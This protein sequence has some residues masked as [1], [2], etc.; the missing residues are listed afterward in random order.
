MHLFHNR[1]YRTK[2]R[3][4]FYLFVRNFAY[5]P[6]V[7]LGYLWISTSQDALTSLG[8]SE[9]SWT[10]I[11]F[12]SRLFIIDMLKPFKVTN[13]Y[14]YVVGWSW[15]YLS[16][17]IDYVYILMLITGKKTWRS[18]LNDTLVVWGFVGILTALYPIIPV[19]LCDVVSPTS[20]AVLE[21]DMFRQLLDPVLGI[22]QYAT[23]SLRSRYI[24][25]LSTFRCSVHLLLL[26]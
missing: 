6:P 2:Y 24:C 11:I 1:E 12:F 21:A 19:W 17:A 7:T 26:A 25:R 4:S 22:P 8:L 13:P 18:G 16:T 5:V 15:A 9:L 20:S 3:D 10:R 14:V 23:I